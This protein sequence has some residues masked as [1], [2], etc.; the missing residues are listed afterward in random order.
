MCCEGRRIRQRR[1]V[2]AKL[3]S[4]IESQ[5]RVRVGGDSQK[6]MRGRG[7]ARRI[8]SWIARCSV[9]ASTHAEDVQGVVLIL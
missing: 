6:P 5:W 8:K 7:N 2:G 4:R 1:V 3:S 9:E